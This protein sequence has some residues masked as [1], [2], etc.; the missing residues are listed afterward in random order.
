MKAD[1]ERILNGEEPTKESESRNYIGRDYSGSDSGIARFGEWVV[2]N[3]KRIEGAKSVPYFLSD[4]KEKVDQALK[5]KEEKKEEK[6]E[7]ASIVD[8][9]KAEGKIDYLPVKEFDEQPSEQQI[10][11]R[12]GGG[13]KTK[14]SCSSLAFAYAANKGGLDVLDFRDGESRKYFA[15]DVNIEEIVA[16]VGGKTHRTAGGHSMSGVELMKEAEVG[17]EYYLAIGRHAAIVRRTG[18]RDY[19]YLELQSSYDNGWHKLNSKVFASRFDAKGRDY[20]YEMIDI[21]KLH[22]D[23]SY[24]ELMGYINTEISKQVKGG[25]IK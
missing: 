18:T 9:I 25:T 3:E 5:K 20:F 13:D 19:E 23:N 8:K 22:N 12:L 17:K 4:N 10:I 14:G 2:N 15:M 24:R 21:T 1:T 11:E 7:L 6:G 16:K